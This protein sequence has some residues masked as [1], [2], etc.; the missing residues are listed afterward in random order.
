MSIRIDADVRW[1]SDPKDE[2]ESIVISGK[3]SPAGS[4]QIYRRDAGQSG[5][6]HIFNGTIDLSA[7]FTQPQAT[8]FTSSQFN[9]TCVDCSLSGKIFPEFSVTVANDTTA[10]NDLTNNIGNNV[11][12]ASLPDVFQN[13]SLSAVVT[14]AVNTNMTLEVSSKS[15][16]FLIIS[17]RFKVADDLA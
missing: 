1:L 2:G 8:L 6:E 12:N 9:V 16:I 15:A 5:D 4:S 14:E 11:G 7:P 10:L 17:K 13:A 3:A